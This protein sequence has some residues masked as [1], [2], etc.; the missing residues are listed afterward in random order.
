MNEDRGFQW[1]DSNVGHLDSHKVSS[2][3]TEE[4]IVDPN[5][6]LLEIQTGAEERAKVVGASRDG[7]IL[8][9]VFTWRGEAI[10][11]ITA[12]DAPVILQRLYLE[13]EHI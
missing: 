4:A 2:A 13:G 8:V 11:P 1:D 10:R 3:E 7:R 5:A 9:V 12:Y 6:I